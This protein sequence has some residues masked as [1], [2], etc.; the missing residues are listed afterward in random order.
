MGGHGAQAQGGMG[1]GDSWG[2]G[3]QGA[4]GQG[5]TGDVEGSWDTGTRA[6]TGH[7]T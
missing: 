6:G 3:G 7:G 1:H 4:W 5:G 2:M